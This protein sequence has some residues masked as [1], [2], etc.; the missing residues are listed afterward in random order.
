M[1]KPYRTFSNNK[2]R[3]DSERAIKLELESLVSQITRLRTQFCVLCG[4]SNWRELECGHFWHRAMPPTEFDLQ[5]LNTLC[6]SCNR[7]HESDSKPYREYMLS[8][9]GEKVFA[10]LE[11]RAHSQTKIG[12]V[13]LFNLREEMRALLHEEKQRVAEEKK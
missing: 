13:E 3:R 6:R 12:Y 9:L 10:Q 2:P 8:T 5:N 4:E 11:W 1:V 7:R